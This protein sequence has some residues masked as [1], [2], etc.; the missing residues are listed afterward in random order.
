MPASIG[1]GLV[2]DRPGDLDAVL[3][4]RFL[5]H[6]IPYRTLFAARGVPTCA[7]QLL[8]ALVELL[9]R[10]HLAGFF[11][12]DCSLSNTLFRL[13]AGALAAYLV[14]AETA[15]LHP[16][17]SRRPARAT[18]SRSPRSNVAG[19]LF[20]LRGRGLLARGVDPVEVADELAAPLRARC[21]TS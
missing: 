21:G 10:L 19:E 6:S 8:D 13:D 17:L 15:E 11:W 2:V 5:D 16:T 7:D 9:V 1:A 14:D 18:T 4:T 3:V 12:G 20:D